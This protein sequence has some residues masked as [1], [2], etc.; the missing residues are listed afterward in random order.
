M[1]L[2]YGKRLS[3][4]FGLIPYI[5]NAIKE[6]WEIR[7]EEI[8]CHWWLP[9][10][11]ICAAVSRPTIY[12]HGTDVM[13]LKRHRWLAWLCR[14]FAKRVKK[15]ICVSDYLASML[16]DTLKVKRVEV[17]PMPISTI[18]HNKRDSR[19]KDTAIIITNNLEPNKR[20]DKALEWARANNVWLFVTGDW[21][22]Y[23]KA[24][25]LGQLSRTELAEWYNQMEYCI[26]TSDYEGYGLSIREA[27]K[28]GCKTVGFV[29]DGRTGD[30]IDIK[31]N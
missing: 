19:I 6:I 16:K 17:K 20:I 14:P 27:K 28:C 12:C 31:L 11:I 25:L 30:I 18:F 15:W 13:M 3:W 26:S 29:G 9:L 22:H 5:I 2:P 10:G 21:G 7:K 24:T 4:S 1:H 23:G 8:E